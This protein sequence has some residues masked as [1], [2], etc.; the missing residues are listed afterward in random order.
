MLDIKLIRQDPQGV[1]AKLKR[2]DP[3][4][5]L[6][7]IVALDETLRKKM[8]QSQELSAQRNALAK[9]IGEEKR[10]GNETTALQEEAS[11]HIEEANTLENEVKELQHSLEQA[12]S[13]LPNIPLDSVKVSEDPKDNVVLKEWREKP[14][15][16]FPFRNHLE[17]NELHHLFDFERGAKISGSGWPVYRGMGAQLEWALLTHMMQ[18]HV[19]HG[20]T[21]H[22]V[23]AV[24]REDVLYQSGQLPKFENQQY[25]FTER[26]NRY[27]LI[28]TSEVPLNGLHADEILEADQLPLKY[29]AYSQ[30]F[31]KE[32]GAAGEKE[33]GLI[34]MHQFNKV[35]MFIFC[36]PAQSS[37][38]FDLMVCHGEHL[39]QSLGLHYRVVSLVTGDMSFAGI[40]T[41][42][43]EVWLPGQNRYYEV[44]SI[45]E[46][47]NFQSLRSGTRFRKDR[48]KPQHVHTLNGSGLATSRL[49]VGLLENN[50]REDGSIVIPEVLRGYLGGTA[51]LEP[52]IHP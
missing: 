52:K 28:P 47:G 46:C 26:E 49:M 40:R 21:P 10:A 3:T 17:L 48:E 51:V 15:F 35:E 31:R 14:T 5:S 42:D 18:E 33:R 24:I 36:T 12:L 34:R 16:D 44:S 2:R 45:T 37:S 8:V 27:F 11:R 41:V 23:P 9:T 32:A 38:M 50:Q 43:L 39:L 25:G 6:S 29:T 20:F 1:E 7:E 30:C 19:R 4:I 22:L 13:R